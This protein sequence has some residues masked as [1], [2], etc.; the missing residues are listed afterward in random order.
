VFPSA[1]L[2]G[3]PAGPTRVISIAAYQAAFEDFD[4]SMAST[5]AMIMGAIQLAIVAAALG[6]RGLVYRGPAGAGK[7]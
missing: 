5:I 7:G 3:A 2:L 1:I 6:A 4:Y